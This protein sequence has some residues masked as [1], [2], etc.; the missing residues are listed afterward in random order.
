[1]RH[2]S[3]AGP[4]PTPRLSAAS[5]MLGSLLQCHLRRGRGRGTAAAPTSPSPRPLLTVTIQILPAAG[6]ARLPHSGGRRPRHGALGVALSLCRLDRPAGE[7]QA[8]RGSQALGLQ[9]GGRCSGRTG[10][11]HSAVPHRTPL[12][13]PSPVAD[14]GA[15]HLYSKPPAPW[16][17]E[18][19]RAHPLA[20]SGVCAV[21]PV[22]QPPAR[23]PA[24]PG[25]SRP[26]RPGPHGLSSAVCRWR[27]AGPPVLQTHARGARLPGN[28]TG[29]RGAGSST[30]RWHRT[31]QGPPAGREPCASSPEER[32]PPGACR[33][34]PAFPSG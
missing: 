13:R 27:L 25:G 20:V 9:A 2:G 17:A 14:C 11:R 4:R 30:W 6:Q 34:L 33:L 22:G 24:G 19:G 16:A 26:G 3:P 28:I 1:M 29:A 23:Q 12:S 21:R 31:G 32:G 7:G 5:S 10:S 15:P 8:D 18:R